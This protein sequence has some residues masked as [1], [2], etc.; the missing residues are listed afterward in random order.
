ELEEA[1]ASLEQRVVERTAELEATHKQLM[2]TAR[3]AGMAE[4]AIGVL[5]NVGNVLNSVNVS[6][7]VVDRKIRKSVAANLEKVT[8]LMRANEDD[9]GAFMTQ[10]ERGR[11]L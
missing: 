11:Q 5:H 6:A 1:N 10:D 3:R 2:E 7:S 8:A 4:V 9:L